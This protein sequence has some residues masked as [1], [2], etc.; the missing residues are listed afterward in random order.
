SFG[1]EYGQSRAGQREDGQP[2]VIQLDRIDDR[3]CLC[4]VDCGGVVQRAV[5][6]QVSDLISGRAREGVER[7]E[8]IDDVGR[9]LRGRDIDPAAT[10]AREVAIADLSADPDAAGHRLLA[11]PSHDRRIPGMEPT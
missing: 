6:F 1:G 4:R 3:S 8:L 5:R 9:Q 7:A 2:S 10:E 11:Y